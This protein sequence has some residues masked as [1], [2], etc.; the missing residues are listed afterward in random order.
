ML[1]IVSDVLAIACVPAGIPAIAGILA[2][3]AI[4][5]VADISAI[6]GVSAV[7]GIP[8]LLFLT[9][10]LVLQGILPSA[11]ACFT[12]VVR[13]INIKSYKTFLFSIAYS[14]TLLI[15]FGQPLPSFPEED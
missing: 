4:L 8:D 7:S 13:T 11:L 9:F 1:V 2:V 3:A 5:A 15:Q 10:S 14:L 12:S 6:V